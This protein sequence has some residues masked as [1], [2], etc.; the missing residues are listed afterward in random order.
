V[1]ELLSE[2]KYRRT[3]EARTGPPVNAEAAA[4]TRRRMASDLEQDTHAFLVQL[5]TLTERLRPRRRPQDAPEPTCSPREL[6]VL[7]ALGRHGR[8]TMTAVAALLEVPLSTATH[9]VNRL[10]A[11]GLVERKQAA[12]DRRV[13]E[14]GFGRRGKTINRFVAATRGSEAGAMLAALSARERKELLKQLAKMV[15]SNTTT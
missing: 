12:R 1:G 5:D 13:I 7:G 8:M 3:I 6:R 4:Y 11:K 9:T 10:A 2:L 14:V 15:D